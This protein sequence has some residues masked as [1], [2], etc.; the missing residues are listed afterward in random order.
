M[1]V[2]WGFGV[3]PEFRMDLHSRA[4]T[5]YSSI[6]NKAIEAALTTK[7]ELFAFIDDDFE[8][9]PNWIIVRLGRTKKFDANCI[10]GK[11]AGRKV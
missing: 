11:I 4:N 6:R 10:L 3:A 8:L 5:G 7:S 9:H 1:I 2:H